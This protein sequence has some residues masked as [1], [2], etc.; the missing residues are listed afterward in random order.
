VEKTDALFNFPFQFS[1][2][3]KNAKERYY[4]RELASFDLS[5][6]IIVSGGEDPAVRY[7]RE[8]GNEVGVPLAG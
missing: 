1:L 6:S 4:V 7:G 2:S 5:H 8:S 3:K